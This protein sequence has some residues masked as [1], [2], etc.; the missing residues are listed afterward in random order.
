MSDGLK[1][2][3][4]PNRGV[5]RVSGPD[6]RAFLD[7]LVTNAMAAVAPGRAAHAALLTPQGKVV[8]DFFVTELDAEDGGGFYLDAP[9]LNA[10]DVARRLGIYRLRARVEIEDMSEA[11]GVVALWGRPPDETGLGLAY[12][13]P[14]LPEMGWRA[15][16][17]RSQAGALILAADAEPDSPEAHHALRVANA[18]PECGFDFLPGE[19]FPHELNMDQLGGVDF[20]KGCY[21]GQEVVS[22]VQ[23]RGTA[24]SRAVGLAYEGGVTVSEGASVTA[25]GRELGRTGSGAHGRG[26][27]ILRLDRAAE[28]LAAGE[29]ILAGGVPAAIVRPAWWT[30]PWPLPSATGQS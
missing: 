12:A 3:L 8:A 21:V 17:H 22:R 23:H 24:R 10:A 7:G 27:A 26:V 28:A 4:L 9:L 1:A 19:A 25:G 29:P 2:A 14:R 18:L 6:A 30:A 5:I 20:R 16:A 11:L 15:I 13:D